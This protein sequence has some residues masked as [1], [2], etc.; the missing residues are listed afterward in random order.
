MA[1]LRASALQ[2]VN[3]LEDTQVLPLAGMTGTATLWVDAAR[4]YS[5][6]YVVLGTDSGV[7]VDDAQ[8][9]VVTS[10]AGISNPASVGGLPEAGI[11]CGIKLYADAN[12]RYEG[13]A[14]LTGVVVSVNRQA[15]I[16]SVAA[17]FVIN[18]TLVGY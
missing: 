13:S 6:P 16:G 18:G 2:M 15:S 4:R 3:Y 7:D 5:V 9:R 17:A 1:G 14:L 10:G 8:R 11:E 12:R